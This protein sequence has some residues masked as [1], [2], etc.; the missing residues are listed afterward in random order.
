MKVDGEAATWGGG[1]QGAA[2]GS[3]AQIA[4]RGRASCSGDGDASESQAALGQAAA[5]AGA[6]GLD[7]PGAGLRWA[8][9]GWGRW[10]EAGATWRPPVG[11]GRAGG[12]AKWR[13]W[14]GWRGNGGGRRLEVGGG[15]RDAQKW[16]GKVYI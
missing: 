2:A 10:R 6:S 1:L 11:S 4:R 13:S 15:A 7:R 9:G 3:A 16:K 8:S 12:G 14:S 5:R